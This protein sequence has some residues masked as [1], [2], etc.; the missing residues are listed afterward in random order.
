MTE[1]DYDL[2]PVGDQKRNSKLVPWQDVRDKI[3]ARMTT[4]EL[5]EFNAASD[6]LMVEYFT[7][8]HNIVK[9]VILE[10]NWD[11]YGQA[12]LA[13]SGRQARRNPDSSHGEWAEDLAKAIMEALG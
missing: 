11:E 1:D 5:E 7:A 9:Q 6:R 4:E 8:R 12:E 10:F 13:E 2:T 3:L